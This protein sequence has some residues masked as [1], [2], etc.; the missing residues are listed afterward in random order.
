[1]LKTVKIGMVEYKAIKAHAK[2]NG[3]YLQYVLTEAIRQYLAAQ[4]DKAA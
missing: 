3:H 2:K 4:S 1:M